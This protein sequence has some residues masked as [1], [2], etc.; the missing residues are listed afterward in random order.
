MPNSSI[1]LLLEAWQEHQVT[2][3]ELITEARQL[4]PEDR[5]LLREALRQTLP[6]QQ[7]AA[8]ATS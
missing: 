3:R 8:V 2:N 1:T 7:T 4:T 6:S 5:S